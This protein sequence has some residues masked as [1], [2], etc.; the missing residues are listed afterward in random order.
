MRTSKVIVAVNKDP[1][2][3]IFRLADYGIVADLFEAVPELT[4][5]IREVKREV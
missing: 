3:P 2:A 4:E 5:A 1:D